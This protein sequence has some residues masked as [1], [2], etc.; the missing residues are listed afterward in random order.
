MKKFVENGGILILL[1]SNILYAEVDYN[2]IDEKITLVQGHS[3]VFDGE[4]AWLS[5][6]E[7][8]KTETSGWVGSNFF[9]CGQGSYN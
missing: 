7:R 2:P 9:N 4:K 1:N 8:W 5:V 6:L 3:W